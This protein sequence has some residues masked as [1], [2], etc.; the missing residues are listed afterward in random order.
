M[1]GGASVTIENC[2]TNCECGRTCEILPGTY[3]AVRNQLRF[4][5]ASSISAEALK[6]LRGIIEQLRDDTISTRAAE[7]QAEAI[8]PGGGRF[9]RFFEGLSN[10][11]RREICIALIGAVAAILV[12]K[13]SSPTINNEN[14]IVVQPT[15]E[16]V[17]PPP[18]NN[19][20]PGLPGGPPLSVKGHWSRI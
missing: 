16:R 7:Q 20:L 17:V 10:K 13:C 3:I 1:S 11:D 12:A 5:A 15:I 2:V 6:A 18:R 14:K 4:L 19:I 9:V 8:A